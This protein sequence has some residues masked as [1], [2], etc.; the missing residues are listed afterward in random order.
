LNEDERFGSEIEIDQVT[1]RYLRAKLSNISQDRI[2]FDR[3]KWGVQAAA[4]P[5]RLVTV[6]RNSNAPG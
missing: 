1:G 5:W 3:R 4:A 6:E 2:T